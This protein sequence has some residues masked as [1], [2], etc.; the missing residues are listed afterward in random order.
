M[1]TK[2]KKNTNTTLSGGIVIHETVSGVL[3]FQ[4]MRQV[5]LIYLIGQGV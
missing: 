2:P 5:L 3:P 4:T 1:S